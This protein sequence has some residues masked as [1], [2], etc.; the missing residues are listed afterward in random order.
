MQADAWGF[1]CSATCLAELPRGSAR[2]RKVTLK[3]EALLWRGSDVAGK[4]CPRLDLRL[5]EVRITVNPTTN[6]ILP[7]R[8]SRVDRKRDHVPQTTVQRMVTLCFGVTN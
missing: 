8:I 1:V 2:S 5:V 6:A 4:V 3:T 7:R